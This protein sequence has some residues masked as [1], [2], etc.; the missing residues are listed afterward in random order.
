[1]GIQIEGNGNVIAEVTSASSTTEHPRALRASLPLTSELAGFVSLVSEQD[2]G[3]VTG[4]RTVKELEG[5]EDYRLRVGLDSPLFHEFFPGAALNS[6]VWT[7]PVTTMTVTVTGGLAT[8][9]AGLS[10]ANA[11]VARVSSYRSFPAFATCELYAEIVAQLAQTPVASNVT[12]WGFGIASGTTAPTDGAVFR[13]LANGEFRCVV[14]NN[15]VEIQS[16]TLDFNAL[17]GTNTSRH[18]LVAIGDDH[19]KFWI[20]D[21]MVARIDRGAAASSMT[22]SG[23]MPLLFRTY[24][25]GVTSAAQVLRIGMAS[26]QVGDMALCKPMAHLCAGAGWMAYQGQT[27]GTMGTTATYANSADPAAAAGLSNTTAAVGSG[28]GGQFRFNAAATA[29]TDGI[30]SSFQVPAGTAALPGKTLYITGVKIAAV[31]T[32]AAVATTATLLAWSLAFG[33]TAVSLATAEAATTKAPRR[34]ALGLMAWPIGAAIA[35]MPDKGDLYMPFSSPIAVQPG[36][37]VQTVAKFVI[38]TAT[39]SQVILCHVTFDA[40][41]E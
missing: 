8:L 28:L 36:E 24:N 14:I 27:G 26:V 29:T 4:T 3:T 1:V 11:V 5:S 30:V 13:L 38:G 6:A 21:V 2:A 9:N 33:H 16:G 40:Y 15:S 22:A 39:A 34:I 31:N 17:V 19:V 37:F 35:A 23:Q 18:F 25:T 41:Y 32:G 12:E 7:A 10:T 20:D